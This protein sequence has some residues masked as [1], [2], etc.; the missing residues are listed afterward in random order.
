[1]T[2][3]VNTKRLAW[4]S[5][6][7]ARSHNGSPRLRRSLLRMGEALRR[8]WLRARHYRHF[9]GLTRLTASGVGICLGGRSEPDESEEKE[10][11]TP[12]AA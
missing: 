9:A 1:M 5:H 7:P 10:R 4:H 3:C 2:Y 8:A 12:Q 6:S 11:S